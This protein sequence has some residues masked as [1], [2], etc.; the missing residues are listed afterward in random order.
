M[1]VAAKIA[2]V[3]VTALMI[4]AGSAFAGFY[5]GVRIG[6]KTMTG[7]AERNEAHEALS[8]ASSA[9]VALG[10]D[11]LQLSQ[12]QL[13]AQLRQSLFRLGA[14]ATARTYFRCTAREWGVLAE[15]NRYLAVHADRALTSHP[16]VARGVKFCA[17][18]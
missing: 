3:S 4:T 2:L 18:E 7:M 10:K 14:L 6:A 12:R 1:R 16:F 15:A 9:L 17:R 8:D 11:D 13:A 5:A